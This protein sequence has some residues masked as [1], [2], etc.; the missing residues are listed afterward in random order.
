MLS[1]EDSLLMWGAS[2][3][4]NP[5]GP[6]VNLWTSGTVGHPVNLWTTGTVGH[7]VNVWTTGTV[8]QR[9]YCQSSV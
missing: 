3:C 6:P 1:G 8:G 7:P 5:L 4:F 2:V 9:V